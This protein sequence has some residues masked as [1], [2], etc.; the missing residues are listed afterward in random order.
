MCVLYG[1]VLLT[2][3]CSVLGS[4][5]ATLAAP[6]AQGDDVAW[7]YLGRQANARVPSAPITP[8]PVASGMSQRLAITDTDRNALAFPFT[9][10][11]GITWL[12]TSLMMGMANILFEAFVPDLV[13]EVLGAEGVTLAGSGTA[14]HQAYLAAQRKRD[15]PSSPS[16]ATSRVAVR[17]SPFPSSTR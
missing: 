8:S 11:G 6:S 15:D 16:C 3:P 7:L 9:H 1:S 5:S 4:A 14:F 17:P 12:F 10:V 2:Q 13:V